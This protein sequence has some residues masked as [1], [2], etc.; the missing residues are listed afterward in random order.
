MREFDAGAL[1]LFPCITIFCGRIRGGVRKYSGT[2]DLTSGTGAT[3]CVPAFVNGPI[4]VGE[5]SM[6]GAG[7]LHSTTSSDLHGRRRASRAAH[8]SANRHTVGAVFL[9]L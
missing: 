5:R 1:G 7:A 6:G 4:R 8:H 3:F 9:M 2:H